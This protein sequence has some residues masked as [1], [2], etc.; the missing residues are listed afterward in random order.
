MPS[1]SKWGRHVVCGCGFIPKGSGRSFAFLSLKV[2]HDKT[3]VGAGPREVTAHWEL[4]PR[5]NYL[6]KLYRS[7]NGNRLSFVAVTSRRTLIELP[8]L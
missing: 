1:R 6:L 4:L 2:L 3:M 7:C 5:S 8:R